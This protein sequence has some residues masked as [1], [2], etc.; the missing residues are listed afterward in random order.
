MALNI[1][2]IMECIGTI[3]LW[4]NYKKNASPL[5]TYVGSKQ[6]LSMINLL[7]LKCSIST[8]GGSQEHAREFNSNKGPYL[9]IRLN[10]T[11]AKTIV[12]LNKVC[13]TTKKMINLYTRE[14]RI[15]GE[16]KKSSI[17]LF[18]QNEFTDLSE[19]KRK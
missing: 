8:Q 18:L 4:P 16:T 2:N 6:K 1:I 15:F 17:K 5:Y 13:K 7:K 19:F 14:V 3:S 10:L 9:T 11:W 12:S